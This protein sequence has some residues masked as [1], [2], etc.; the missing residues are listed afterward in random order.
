MALLDVRLISGPDDPYK[1]VF[2]LEKQYL[3]HK[4]L[5]KHLIQAY[6]DLYNAVGVFMKVAVNDKAQHHGEA[7]AQN[8][9]TV[10]EDG[11]AFLTNSEGIEGSKVFTVCLK[12]L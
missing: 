8:I 1:W 7:Q 2:L 10:H 9:S 6:I 3:F 5:S 11:E 12:L 4:N